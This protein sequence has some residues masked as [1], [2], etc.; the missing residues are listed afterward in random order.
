[1][2]SVTLKREEDEE[3]KKKKQEVI[4]S[5][6]VDPRV[7]ER[8]EQEAPT[9]FASLPTQEGGTE[10][11]N[12]PPSTTAQQ[13]QQRAII[14]A[15]SPEEK[16]KLSAEF[17]A[18][19]VFDTPELVPVIDKELENSGVLLDMANSLLGFREGSIGLK[20]VFGGKALKGEDAIRKA[21]KRISETEMAIQN[22]RVDKA[23]AS[24]IGKE[25][26][27]QIEDAVKEMEIVELGLGISLVA[28]ATAGGF[29][30]SFAQL[31]GT[32]KKVKNLTTGIA[33][34]ET[35]AT[36]IASTVSSGD[37]STE[38]GF[39]RINDVSLILNNMEAELQRAAIES[40]NVRISLKGRDVAV[41]IFSARSRL[42]TS[43]REVAGFRVEG[44]IENSPAHQKAAL[45]ADLQGRFNT[46]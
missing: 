19:G 45:L 8:V 42:N 44:I 36:D 5:P 12:L 4:A 38:E 31:I 39:N 43:L 11:G 40:A 22:N 46:Q 29:V 25:Y 9:G 30:S 7:I 6:G 18:A 17:G 10:G 35:I 37:M 15:T 20:E 1:M 3:K 2:V 28:G 26:D 24:E 32:D 23:L 21:D 14:E 41:K 13:E 27:K 16:E 33:K 34:L